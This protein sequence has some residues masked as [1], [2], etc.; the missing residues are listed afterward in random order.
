MSDHHN[1]ETSEQVT[2]TA[3]TARLSVKTA[4]SFHEATANFE[5]DLSKPLRCSEKVEL[6]LRAGYN[7]TARPSS[8]EGTVPQQGWLAPYIEHDLSARTLRSSEKVELWIRA[9]FSRPVKEC[10]HEGEGISM[11]KSKN[12]TEANSTESAI[13]SLAALEILP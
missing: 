5:H 1:S 6:W 11:Q 4:E 12:E 3:E 13:T 2:E 8:E 10:F 7:E 9:H